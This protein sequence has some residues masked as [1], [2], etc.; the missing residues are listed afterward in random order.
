MNISEIELLLKKYYDGET[1]LADE[2]VLRSFFMGSEVPE[3]LNPHKAFFNW[4]VQEKKQTLS[5]TDFELSLK[6]KI[7]LS[8][9]N[10]DIGG[11]RRMLIPRMAQL[12]VAATVLIMISIVITWQLTTEQPRVAA[13]QPSVTE[14]WATTSDALALVSVKFNVGLNELSRINH[15]DHAVH[16]LESFNKFFKSQNSVINTEALYGASQKND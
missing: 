3:H 10:S 16:N 11:K 13:A 14:A 9:T 1:T 2:S 7:K 6:A 12:A 8:T 15:F 4:A 5:N